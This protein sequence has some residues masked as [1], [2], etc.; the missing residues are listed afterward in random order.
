MSRFRILALDIDGTLVGPRDDEVSPR[1]REALARARARGIR[2]VL[3]TGRRYSR[4]FPLA[5]SLDLDTPVVTASGALVKDPLDHRTIHVSHI[6]RDTLVS[7]LQVVRGEGHLAVLYADTFHEGFDFYF[8]RSEETRPDLADFY[9][10]NADSGKLWPDLMENPPQ[11]VFASFALGTKV[12]MRAL[13][14]AIEARLPGRL[15]IHV[16][17]SPRYIAYMCEIAGIG[18]T[19]WSAVQQLARQ[20]GIADVEICAV[21]DDVND[22]PM[23]VGAGLGIAMGNAQ[24]EVKAMADRIAPDQSEDGLEKVVTWILQE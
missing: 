9:G 6:D 5:R 23:I 7:M 17:R 3:T 12:E 8:V 22:I 2:V 21:G 19:K 24:P 18:V 14:D 20:W 11:G 4:V 15:Y 16:L 1:V 10:R 13:A